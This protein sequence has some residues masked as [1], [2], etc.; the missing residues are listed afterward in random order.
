MSTNYVVFTAN[1]DDQNN[2]TNAGY[3]ATSGVLTADQDVIADTS[4]VDFSLVGF[5][6][7][8]TAGFYYDN[9]TKQNVLGYEPGAST[10][11]TPTFTYPYSAI[12]VVGTDSPAPVTWTYVGTASLDGLQGFVAYDAGNGLY[13]FFA[14]QSAANRFVTGAAFT[15]GQT[16]PVTA[17]MA[18]SHFGN[19]NWNVEGAEIPVPVCFCRGTMIATAGGQKAVEGLKAGDMVLTEAG[20]EVPVRWIGRGVFS[21]VFADQSRVLPVLVRAGALGDNLPARDLRVSPGHAFLL[22]GVLVN[23]GALVNGTTI[24][25]DESTPVVFEYF[26]VE[27]DRHDVL[28]AEGV[29]AES[30]VDGVENMGFEN[31]A[32]R[33]AGGAMQEMDLPRAKSARQVPT[34]VRARI[35]ARVAVLT[36]GFALAA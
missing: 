22:D 9:V 24:L 16:T 29:P 19:G 26:H 27:L 6:I 21:R 4:P 13:G 35:A 18:N 5:A 2:V 10:V 12:G 32:E 8:P 36:E 20:A 31:L 28:M 33:P 23:A 25:R 17:P 15:S 1:P 14:E 7:T 3:D 11:V 34:A 30:F